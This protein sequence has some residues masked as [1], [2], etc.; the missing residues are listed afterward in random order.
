MAAQQRKGFRHY[1][2]AF[3]ITDSGFG[4]EALPII[5]MF[6]PENC[7]LIRVRRDGCDFSGDSRSYVDLPVKT[8]DVKNAGNSVAAF[9]LELERKA[10]LLFMEIT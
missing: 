7:T 2:S 3:T 1:P 4:P 9:Q 10:P 6:D 8:I 5:K